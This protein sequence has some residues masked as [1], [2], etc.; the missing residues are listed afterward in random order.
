MSDLTEWSSFAFVY[1]PLK[2]GSIDG[3]DTIPHDHGVVRAMAAK[4][5]PNK[6]V[7]GDPKCTVFVGRLN[8][9]TTQD[10]LHEYFSKFGKVKNCRLVR[11]LVTG[12]SKGYGF[13]EYFEEKHAERAKRDGDQRM[14]DGKEILV[15]SEVERTL[16]GWIPRRLGGGFGG[17]K[18]AGQLR[19]GGKDRPFRKPISAVDF[20][21]LDHP[22]AKLNNRWLRNGKEVDENWIRHKPY[23]Q[24]KERSRHRHYDDRTHNHDDPPRHHDRASQQQDRR[25]SKDHRRHRS[26]SRDRY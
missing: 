21:N 4:Y 25:Y 26:R 6:N 22:G 5:K 11:N 14:F 2:C 16:K 9:E 7:R 17:K 10:T 13:I 12:A 24:E 3:T 15:T 18:E 23:D 19:F 1:D 20:S 8:H